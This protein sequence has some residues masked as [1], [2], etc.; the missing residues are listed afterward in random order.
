SHK[1]RHALVHLGD[2]RGD[3]LLLF[4]F[5]E[6]VEFAVRAEDEYA[7]NAASYEVVE[8]PL[9]PWQVQVFVV[10][11]RRGN[12]RNDSVNLHPLVFPIPFSC[13]PLYPSPS[14]STGCA[15]HKSR[16]LFRRYLPICSR[17]PT[18]PAKTASAPVSRMFFALRCPSRSAI[19]GCVML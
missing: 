9:Q 2:G 7:V 14:A 5:V 12:G 4:A 8:E 18:L 3:D 16:V 17:Q 19:S 6:C 10:A 13:S 15:T 11:H 1:D